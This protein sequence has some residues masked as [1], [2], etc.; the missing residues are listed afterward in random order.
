VYHK[1]YISLKYMTGYA[2]RVSKNA[3]QLVDIAKR[4]KPYCDTIVLYE[5]NEDANRIHC[6]LYLGGV[7]CTTKRLK[8]VSGL[9]NQG[10]SLWSFKK[11][12]ED[13]D[14]YITYMSKGKYDPTYLHGYEFK[15]TERL[16][17]LWVEPEKKKPK[18]LEEYLKF[19]GYVDAQPREMKVYDED[20]L[21]LARR[22]I[23]LRDS[24]FT[25]V[26]QNQIKNYAATYSFKHY[27][28][29]KPKV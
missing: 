9:P 27:L 3:E 1:K 5:H 16:K 17:S 19:E 24:M 7:E 13:I 28:I 22:Y 23:M 26:N 8:Q 10:N 15:D 2:V 11:A 14:V 12:E 25:M 18:A 21:R 4:W 20:I 29:S 6:H